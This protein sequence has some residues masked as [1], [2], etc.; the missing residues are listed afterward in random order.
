VGIIALAVA[1]AVGIAACG[2][3]G[4]RAAKEAAYAS[5]LATS[6]KGAFAA[7]GL[8]VDDASAQCAGKQAVD[9]LGVDAFEKAGM[10]PES[11]RSQTTL[12]PIAATAPTRDQATRLAAAFYGCVDVGS[13]VADFLR[14]AA[15]RKG[16]TLPADTWACVR[17]NATKSPTLRRA[18]ADA[19]INGGRPGL[20]AADSQ[21]MASEI[22]GG[23]L[24]PAQMFQLAGALAGG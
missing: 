12:D 23:C 2:G 7:E 17:A 14:S 1:L 21:V 16:V 10:T 9:V 5:A 20:G 8:A 3:G 15:E 11:I 24:T 4:D 18:L 22:L 6:L 13:L 19:L